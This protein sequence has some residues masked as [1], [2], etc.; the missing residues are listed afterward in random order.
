MMKYAHEVKSGQGRIDD[1]NDAMR[2]GSMCEDQMMLL[3]HISMVCNVENLKKQD[4]G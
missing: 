3:L 1:I 4:F 2:W